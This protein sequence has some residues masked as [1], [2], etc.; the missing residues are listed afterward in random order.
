MKIEDTD[1]ELLLRLIFAAYP[2]LAEQPSKTNCFERPEP[3][4]ENNN[5][6]QHSKCINKKELYSVS[7]SDV[8]GR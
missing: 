6:P 7:V 2:H 3:S 8:L 5:W 4:L 1:R